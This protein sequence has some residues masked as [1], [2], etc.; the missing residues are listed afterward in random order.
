MKYKVIRGIENKKGKRYEAGEVLDAAQLKG[1]SVKA[2]LASGVLKA[3]K[4][5]DG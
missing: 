4:D 1:W 5:G 2:W 3:V